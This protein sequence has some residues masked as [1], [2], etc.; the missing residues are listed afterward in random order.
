LGQPCFLIAW[1]IGGG[2]GHIVQI[3]AVSSVLRARGVRV[4]LAAPDPAL[5]IA[6]GHANPQFQ[7]DA[8][9]QSPL[10]RTAAHEF[11]ARPFL[12]YA[13]LMLEWGF[14]DATRLANLCGA[15]RS[16]FDHIKPDAVLAHHAPVAGWAANEA[17]LP[18][19]RIGDGFTTPPAVSPLPSFTPWEPASEAALHTQ[20]AAVA[21]ILGIS[22]AAHLDDLRDY[23]LTWPMLDH[24]GA[25]AGAYYYGPIAAKLSGQ[26]VAWPSGKG[27]R[28][29]VYL[30]ARHPDLPAVVDAIGQLGW[31]AVL[32]SPT[33][34][35]TVPPNITLYTTPIDL[36]AALRDADLLI[37]HTPH[38]TSVEALRA[39]KPILALPNTAEQG[40]IAQRLLAL[41]VSF[42]AK[43]SPTADELAAL[44]KQGL[45]TPSLAQNAAHMAQSLAVYD[46]AQAAQELAEDIL[47]DLL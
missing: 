1:E 15:W 31:P 5:P 13:S 30:S 23:L 41:G 24:Y 42:M 38:G 33:P 4:V 27:P 40:M 25:R 29:A 9:M 36:A 19:G 10:G 39:G 47:A 20:D 44:L 16:L 26:C 12:N 22:P 8:I 35:T 11:S 37:C 14:D 45:D 34:P 3:A 18:C 2:F 32:H 7:F 43:P 6:L 46:A 21:A 17:G 28:V